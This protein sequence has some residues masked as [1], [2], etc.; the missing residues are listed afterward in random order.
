MRAQNLI[1]DGSPRWEIYRTVPVSVPGGAAPAAQQ[2]AA[3]G[4]SGATGRQ[5]TSAASTS[6]NGGGQ[7]P[8]A[9]SGGLIFN[10]DSMKF[11]VRCSLP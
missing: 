6:N 11:E 10:A 4:S 3:P 5:R 1:I 8:A 7:L 9:A 2:A